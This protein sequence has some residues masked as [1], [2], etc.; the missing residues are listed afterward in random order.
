[1][2]GKVPATADEVEQREG[3]R[4]VREGDERVGDDVE[5][6]DTWLPEVA[7]PVGHELFGREQL[8]EKVEHGFPAARDLASLTLRYA[9]ELASSP[10]DS[11]GSQGIGSA[12]RP[13]RRRNAA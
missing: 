11:R 12:P 3:D 2:E 6:D 4:G 8:R 5:P 10:L 13:T 7:M 1:M 9:H